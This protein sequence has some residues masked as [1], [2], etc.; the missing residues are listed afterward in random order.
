MT[1]E[2]WLVYL[3]S[4]YPNG[5]FMHLWVV[6]LVVFAVGIMFASLFHFGDYRDGNENTVWSK[7]GKWKIV[8]PSILVLFIFL[9]LLV[10]KRDHFILILATPYAVEAGKSLAD[11]LSD[12]TSKMFKLN[13]LVDKSLEKMLKE[14]SEPGSGKNEQN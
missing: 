9:S 13:Q 12:P 3:W 5:G 10:P 4:I 7:I 1:N 11:S 2:Q 14:L 6:L 8:I